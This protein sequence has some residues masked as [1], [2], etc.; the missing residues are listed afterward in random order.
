MK[1]RLCKGL[2]AGGT[3]SMELPESL[4]HVLQ[5]GERKKNWKKISK[6]K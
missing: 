6:K 1:S 2:P 3:E 4:L 5:K